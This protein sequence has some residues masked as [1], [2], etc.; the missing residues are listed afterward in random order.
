MHLLFLARTPPPPCASRRRLAPAPLEVVDDFALRLEQQL[1][2]RREAQHLRAFRSNFRDVPEVAAAIFF[3]L[4]FF[5][6]LSS[7]S[8]SKP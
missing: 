1:D 2:L 8:H 5:F 3:L 7:S 6:L 4:P